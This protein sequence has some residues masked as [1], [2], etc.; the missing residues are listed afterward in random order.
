MTENIVKNKFYQVL[1]E[2]LQQPAFSEKAQKKETLRFF[3]Q[4]DL[5]IEDVLCQAGEGAQKKHLGHIARAALY[6]RDSDLYDC[7]LEKE[8]DLI[9]DVFRVADKSLRA[10]KRDTA[11]QMGDN[12][13]SLFY[14]KALD[15]ELKSARKG[16]FIMKTQDVFAF[17]ELFL[18]DYKRIK[19]IESQPQAIQKRQKKLALFFNKRQNQY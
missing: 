8:D 5:T 15:R 18:P 4:N 1:Q 17:L 16:C 12:A 10:S 7:Y 14:Q 3:I 19:I 6:G 2:A 9:R 13:R 11:L